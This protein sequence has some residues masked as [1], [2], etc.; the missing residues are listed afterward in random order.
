MNYDNFLFFSIFSKTYDRFDKLPYNIQF[1][2][3][4]SEFEKWLKFDQINGL[5]FTKTES[6]INFIAKEYY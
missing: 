6:I 5:K 1:Q 2:I 3:L 4:E